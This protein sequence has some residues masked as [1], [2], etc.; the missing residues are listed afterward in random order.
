MASQPAVGIDLGT[1]NSAAAR[2]GDAGRTVM[3]RNSEG[4]LLT[5]SVVL[6]ED[7]EVVV[8]KSAQSATA[9]RPELV[10]Q[11]AKRD[12]GLAAYSRPIRGEYLPPEVIQACILRKL[13]A[14][15][16]ETLGCDARVVITVPAYF[17]EPRRK[18]TADAGDMAGLDVLDIVNEPTAAALSFGETAGYLTDSGEIREAMTVLVF[19][20]GGGTFDVTVLKLAPGDIRTLATDGDV[21]LGGHDWDSRLVDYVADSFK[22]AGGLDPRDDPGALNRLYSL[23]V[24]AKHTL[25]ART[26]TSIRVDHGPETLD[27]EVTRGKFEDLTADLLERTSHTTRGLLKD[28]GLDWP[29][30]ARILLVGGATRMPMVVRFLHDLSGLTPDRTVNP[31]EAVARGAAIYA[32]YLLAKEDDERAELDFEVTNVNSHS[33]GVEGIEPETM[34][35]TNVVLIPRNMPLPAKCTEKFTTKRDGQQSIVV[36]VLEGES[37]LPEACS[38]IGRTVVRDLPSGL[39]QGWPI[40]ITFEYG[41]N[42]R[43]E[44]TAVIPGKNRQVALEME[45]DGGLSQQRADEWKGAVAASASEGFDAFDSI[46]DDVLGLESDVEHGGDSPE[47]EVPTPVVAEENVEPSRPVEHS[48]TFSVASASEPPPLVRSPPPMQDASPVAEPETTEPVSHAYATPPPLQDDSPVAEPE[49]AESA[50]QA[51]ATPRA[52]EPEPPEDAPH[53]SADGPEVTL[54]EPAQPAASD[55]PEETIDFQLEPAAPRRRSFLWLFVMFIYATSVPAGLGLGYLI[56]RWLAP[57]STFTP[58]W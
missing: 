16:A 29:D 55:Q 46:L 18:A 14:D 1:T 24:E 32:N 27:V 20:L 5:P 52:Q 45:R 51:D 57:D 37:S 44:V 56:I 39:P 2:I 54:E 9:V 11:W 17:D 15:I 10:A 28:A 19:D 49:T 42:G 35:K 30:I 31:D 3:V 12:M 23:V 34:R 13:N 48:A 7:A 26:H 41:A 43:L 36:Q 6:F 4:D 40:E 8:G 33:L 50:P 21:Q 38:V 58:P 22:E 47:K 25:S 53:V